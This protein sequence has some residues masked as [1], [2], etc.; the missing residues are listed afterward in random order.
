MGRN[1]DWMSHGEG[2]MNFIDSL[3]HK[4]NF[5]FFQK[6]DEKLGESFLR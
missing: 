4:K 3:S 1:N 6:K 5:V 2:D